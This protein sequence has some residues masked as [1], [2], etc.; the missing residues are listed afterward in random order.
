MIYISGIVELDEDDK[1]NCGAAF[2]D[3]EH[4]LK[5]DVQVYEDTEI[6]NSHARIKELRDAGK[7]TDMRSEML[8]RINMLSQCDKIYMLKGWETSQV[9]RAEYEYARA[10][11]MRYVYSKK[12]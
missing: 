7:I 8:V 2:A 9:S 10:V 1:R 11:G 6:I 5:H 3:A 4:Y 12:F